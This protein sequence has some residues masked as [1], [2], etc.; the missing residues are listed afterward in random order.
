MS[1]KRIRWMG[2]LALIIYPGKW[3]SVGIPDLILRRQ[4][5]FEGYEIA[6]TMPQMTWLIIGFGLLMF[7]LIMKMGMEMKEEQ[8]LTI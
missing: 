3:L 8:D 1:V 6:Q 7:S 4:I 5:S 2:W